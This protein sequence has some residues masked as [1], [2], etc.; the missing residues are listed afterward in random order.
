MASFS[1]DNLI[2]REGEQCNFLTARN[3][4]RMGNVE[5]TANA[6]CMRIPFKCAFQKNTNTHITNQIVVL[7]SWM[8]KIK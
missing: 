2:L 5:K 1:V 3:V 7:K 6:C 8:Q 4:C